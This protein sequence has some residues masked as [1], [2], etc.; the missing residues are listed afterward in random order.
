MPRLLLLRRK[1]VSLP[2]PLNYAKTSRDNGLESIRVNSRGLRLTTHTRISRTRINI[3]SNSAPACEILVRS[4]LGN[5]FDRRS[6]LKNPSGLDS[7]SNRSSTSASMIIRILIFL[8][9][10][11]AA[12][13]VGYLKVKRVS[14]RFIRSPAFGAQILIKGRLLSS[15]AFSFA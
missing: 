11:F 6:L 3:D 9:L 1:Q 7:L 14:I 13:G 5:G 8:V 15:D 10:N 4:R 2:S 12:L